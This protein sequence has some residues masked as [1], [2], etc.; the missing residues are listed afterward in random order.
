MRMGTCSSGHSSRCAQRP[1]KQPLSHAGK[2]FLRAHQPL[3]LALALAPT[4]GTLP[5]PK[6][7]RQDVTAT[8]Y[9]NAQM[10]S[11]MH[12]HCCASRMSP[13]RPV[14][15]LYA[16]LVC[17]HLDCICEC[18]CVYVVTLLPHHIHTALTEGVHIH[19][20]LALQGA[21]GGT[22]AA[23]S[24]GRLNLRHDTR[25][26][27]VKSLADNHGCADTGNTHRA[28]F[29]RIPLGSMPSVSGGK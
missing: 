9:A 6:S 7:N 19:L 20:I 5:G 24:F 25:S 16:G 26:G 13:K 8:T 29:K 2:S 22:A 14:Q 12:R 18:L 11:Y 4:S 3:A 23:G 15:A 21:A 17:A 28:S 27:S 10:H 1:C